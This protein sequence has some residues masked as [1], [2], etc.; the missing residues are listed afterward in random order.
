LLVKFLVN[1]LDGADSCLD[2]VYEVADLLAPSGVCIPSWLLIRDFFRKYTRIDEVDFGSLGSLTDFTATTDVT[3]NVTT[4]A[5]SSVPKG[6]QLGL[7]IRGVPS[8]AAPKPA[9]KSNTWIARF[10]EKHGFGFFAVEFEAAYI[11]TRRQAEN[12]TEK[13]ITT[14]V[15]LCSSM[16]ARKMANLFGDRQACCDVWDAEDRSATKS[17]T[18]IA[19]FLRSCDGFTPTDKVNKDLNVFKLE[20]LYLECFLRAK[21]TT[22][23]DVSG[24]TTEALCAINVKTHG[25]YLSRKFASKEACALPCLGSTVKTPFF[26]GC[27]GT[28]VKL[29][30][31]LPFQPNKKPGLATIEFCF[32]GNSTKAF[33]TCLVDDVQLA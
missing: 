18:W 8:I 28:I 6:G 27:L 22:F 26:N 2:K 17:Y 31:D 14:L 25:Q 29:N 32:G 11:K 7:P 23:D 1:T 10:L 13:D 4:D 5:T 21:L 9:V 19:R 20:R 24:M 3:T 12:L 16:N 30:V 33:M 15:P